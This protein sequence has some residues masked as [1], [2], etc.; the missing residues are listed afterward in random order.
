M[1]AIPTNILLIRLRLIGDVVFTTPLVGALKRTFPDARLTYLVEREAAPVVAANP[2]LD[3]LIVVAKSRRL[4]ADA[5]T[6]YASLCR[7]RRARFDLVIDLHGGPRSAWL[8]LA[9]GAPARI[10][11]D[12]QGRRWIYTRR[13]HRPRAACSR[14]TRSLNQWDLLDAAR[15]MAGCRPI[16]RATR[17]RCRWMPAAS[18]RV[19]ARLGAPASRTATR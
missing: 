8:T 15:R 17:W 19:A 1:S 11:Y 16:R 9:T 12:V 4:A 14:D 3:E 2:H 6:M 5:A 18:Q 10:G 13:V 7:L